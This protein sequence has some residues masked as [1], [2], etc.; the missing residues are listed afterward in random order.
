MADEI[1]DSENEAPDAVAEVAHVPEETV[2]QEV[3]AAV[4]YTEKDV[5]SLL[6]RL[7]DKAGEEFEIVKGFLAKYL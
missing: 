3:T 1:I 7:I 4:E 6:D 5:A 2:V